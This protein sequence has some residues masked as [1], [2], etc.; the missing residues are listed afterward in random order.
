VEARD[1]TGEV[2]KKKQRKKKHNWGQR[3]PCRKGG[4][5]GRT[6]SPKEKVGVHRE[7]TLLL[8]K[9]TRPYSIKISETGLKPQ[10]WVRTRTRGAGQVAK[11]SRP[12]ASLNEGQ[13]TK[14]TTEPKKKAKMQAKRSQQKVNVE[15]VSRSEKTG[16]GT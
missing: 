9:K 10:G 16:S 12:T 8:K 7:G 11:K 1:P 15:N 6:K 13:K 2:E 5:V 4:V 14:N 3:N